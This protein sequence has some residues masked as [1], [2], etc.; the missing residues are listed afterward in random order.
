MSRMSRSIMVGLSSVLFAC[1]GSSPKLTVSVEGD[2]SVVSA[3]EGINCGAG[4]QD[5]AFEFE[6]GVTVVLS[7][8]PGEG[9]VFAGWGGVCS[10]NAT[11]EVMFD[12]KADVTAEFVASG[13]DVEPPS[14]PFGML[15]AVDMDEVSISWEPSIDNVFSSESLIYRVYVSNDRVTLLDEANLVAQVTGNEELFVSVQGVMPDTQY[16]GAI[17]A[18]DGALNESAPVIS[19]TRTPIDTPEARSDIISYVSD[20]EGWGAPVCSED[21]GFCRFEFDSSLVVPEI[22]A[23]IAYPDPEIPD[24]HSLVAVQSVNESD[25]VVVVVCRP[26]LI[27]EISDEVSI[28]SETISVV[29][30]GWIRV[31][32]PENKVDV[33]KK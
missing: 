2:G 31:T 24:A 18:V 10:G 32:A 14:T 28:Q 6:P 21:T 20:D 25:G 26:A 9:Y 12:K 3:P 15:N 5:C 19:S 22:G 33:K 1:G 11:C 4:L 23:Y 27:F 8:Q 30:P 7:A 29:D 16:F 17:I 13:G